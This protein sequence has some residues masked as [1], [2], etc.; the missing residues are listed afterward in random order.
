MIIATNASLLAG[1]FHLLDDAFLAE[2]I[3][4]LTII[5]KENLETDPNSQEAQDTEGQRPEFFRSRNIILLLCFLYD[6]D[7]LNEDF[8]QD[9][10]LYLADRLNEDTVAHILTIIQ[11]SGFK[12]RQNSPGSIKVIQISTI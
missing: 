10:I 9:I 8:M 4:K 11:N 5:L 1:L 6:F 12:I 3:R 7:V 2:F